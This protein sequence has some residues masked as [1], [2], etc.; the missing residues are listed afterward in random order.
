MLYVDNLDSVHLD[1]E[2]IKF[3]L[4]SFLDTFKCTILNFLNVK[5]YVINSNHQFLVIILNIYFPIAFHPRHNCTITH[6][7]IYLHVVSSV[8]F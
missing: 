1:F 2:Y 6:F 3:L 5:F 4:Y 7:S 8:V